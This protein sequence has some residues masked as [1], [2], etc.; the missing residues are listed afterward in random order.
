M[1]FIYYL[2]YVVCIM[3]P[4]SLNCPFLFAPSVS[5]TFIYSLEIV[6]FRVCPVS[7]DCTFVITLPLRFSLTFIQYQAI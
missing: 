5:L 2:Q 1:T 7:L 6:Q 3:C 4:V